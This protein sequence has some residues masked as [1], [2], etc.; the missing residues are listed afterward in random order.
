MEL[1]SITYE[2]TRAGFLEKKKHSAALLNLLKNGVKIQGERVTVELCNIEINSPQ[3]ENVEKFILKHTTATD[4]A[5]NAIPLKKDSDID[6]HFGAFS[7]HYYV[8]MLDGLKF[9]FSDMIPESVRKSGKFNFDKVF[10]MG[11]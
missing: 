11:A 4:E 7:N 1:G 9:H 2:H 8:L 6:E 5:G 3:M 10:S